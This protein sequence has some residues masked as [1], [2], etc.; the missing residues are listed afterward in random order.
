MTNRVVTS[1]TTQAMRIADKFGS[2]AKLARAINRFATSVKP[3]H[4]GITLD[5][6]YKWGVTRGER[7]SGGM[8][9]A[10]AWWLVAGA[11]RMEG[12]LLTDDDYYPFQIIDG[13]R[14][15]P[16]HR[17]FNDNC[18]ADNVADDSVES[19]IFD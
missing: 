7:S 19:S 3:G 16:S 18:L 5:G 17:I 8:I 10:N 2:I 1:N 6:V 11:A 13:V 4:K 15:P 14:L 9:P 12:I